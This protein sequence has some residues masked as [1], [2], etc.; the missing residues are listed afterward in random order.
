MV[1]EQKS[2]LHVIGSLKINLMKDT[3]YKYRTDEYFKI[4]NRHVFTITRFF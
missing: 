3:T 2:L 4:W 1:E